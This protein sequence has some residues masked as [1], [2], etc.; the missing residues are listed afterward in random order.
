MYGADMKIVYLFFVSCLWYVVS[1]IKEKVGTASS[2]RPRGEYL[3]IIRA[4]LR[5]GWRKLHNDELHDLHYSQNVIMLV[6]SLVHAVMIGAH[7]TGY[8][9]T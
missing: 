4:Q 3:G 9:T 2:R 5:G 7:K 6:R 1:Y 8:L